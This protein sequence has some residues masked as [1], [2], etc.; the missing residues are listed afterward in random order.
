[1]EH[2]DGKAVIFFS[3]KLHRQIFRDMP[4]AVADPVNGCRQ[5]PVNHERNSLYRFRR[6]NMNRRRQRN[7][8]APCF[9]GIMIPVNNENLNPLLCGPIQL[10]RKSHLRSQTVMAAVVYISGNQKGI[11]MRI[12]RNVHHFLKGSKCS[13][14]DGF[15]PRS[16]ITGP[17]PLKRLPQMK[18]CTVH[19][20]K[21]L[22][23]NSS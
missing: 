20:R 15:R 5:F 16:L 21:M 1:M 19:K 14:P 10:S 22:S 18:I 23:H 4:C 7:I 2:G 17:Q 3:L 12:D 8:R 9:S 13:L 6:K 11:G